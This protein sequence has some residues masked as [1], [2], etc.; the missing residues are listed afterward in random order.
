MH[1]GNERKATLPT[2]DGLTGLK[3]SQAEDSL[4]NK[5]VNRHRV[6]LFESSQLCTQ[7]GLGLPTADPFAW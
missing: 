6:L 7:D 5:C 2:D 1:R 4:A 3:V